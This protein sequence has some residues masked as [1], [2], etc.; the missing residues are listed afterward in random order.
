MSS[1]NPKFQ[2]GTPIA[3]DTGTGQ[4]DPQQ[5]NKFI[6][7]INQPAATQGQMPNY[8]LLSEQNFQRGQQSIPTDMRSFFKKG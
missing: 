1:A 7:W 5:L 6:A 2:I 4:V 8:S 3:G